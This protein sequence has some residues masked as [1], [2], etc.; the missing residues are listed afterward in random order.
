MISHLVINDLVR[1]ALAEDLGHGFDLTSGNVIPAN[2]TATCQ[3]VAREDGIL[4]G[5]AFVSAA[6]TAIDPD[7]NIE[8]KIDDGAPLRPG[9]VIATVTGNA[10]SILMAERV[11]L[12]F[13][14]HMSGIATLTRQYVDAVKH[15]NANICDTRKTLPGLR[16][17]QKYAVKMGGGVNHRFGLDD[18]IMIKDNHIAIAGGIKNA[19]DK[20]AANLPHTKTIE[21]EV[22]TLDQLDQVLNHRMQNQQS[23]HIVLLDNMNSKTLRQAVD[24]VKAHNKTAPNGPLITEASGGVTLHTVA[25]IAETG[26]DYISVGALTHS[27]PSL[28][29]GLDFKKS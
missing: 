21:I 16:A 11:A 25:A 3:F 8:R 29:I 13:L 2:T 24:T 10:A 26:V 28:D 14:T 4:A 18:A 22:D 17:I 9:D 5:S 23:A 6:L 1:R 20:A 12:N 19:L 15:T 27:A 7:I